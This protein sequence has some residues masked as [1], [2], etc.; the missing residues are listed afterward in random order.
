V[1]NVLGAL[2][3]SGEY[4]GTIEMPFHSEM[5]PGTYTIRATDDQGNVY[6]GKLI[7]E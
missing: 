1:F 2:I 5:A 6:L 4:E 3:W 7:V